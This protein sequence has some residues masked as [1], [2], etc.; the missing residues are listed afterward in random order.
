M[1]FYLTIAWAR[2]RRDRGGRGSRSRGSVRCVGARGKRRALMP[3]VAGGGGVGQ[4]GAGLNSRQSVWTAVKCG[5]QGVGGRWCGGGAYASSFVYSI[6]FMSDVA[7]WQTCCWRAAWGRWALRGSCSFFRP[8]RWFCWV[9]LESG[10]CKPVFALRGIRVCRAGPSTEVVAD[11]GG[12][13]GWSQGGGASP[14]CCRPGTAL[15]GGRQ[16]GLS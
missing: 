6:A 2:W 14:I 4:R 10:V 8:H 16:L 15:V 5:V 7:C 9:L 13:L 12:C 1:S 3:G 11:V